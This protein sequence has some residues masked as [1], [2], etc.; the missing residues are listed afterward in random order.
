[1]EE[2][3]LKRKVDME[4]N[5]DKYKPYNPKD[6]PNVPK[7]PTCGSTN[8]KKIPTINRAASVALFG[9]ASSKIGKQFECLN[10]KYK[11]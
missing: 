5:P 6:N 7:C 11:W 2:T 8:I 4:L 9:F 10:C 1:M 3:I